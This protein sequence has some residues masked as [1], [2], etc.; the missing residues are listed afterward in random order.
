MIRILLAY[1]QVDLSNCTVVIANAACRDYLQAVKLILADLRCLELD[2]SD[3]MSRAVEDEATEVVIYLLSLPE[4]NP[5]YDNNSALRHSIKNGDATVV[6]A[7]LS[8]PRVERNNLSASFSRA[9]ENGYTEVVR[10]LLAD[11]RFKLPCMTSGME[12]AIERNRVEVVRLI[13]EDGR[14]N[15]KYLSIEQTPKNCSVEMVKLLLSDKR[16][17]PTTEFNGA[18]RN[19]R[20]FK[21]VDVEMLLLQDWR[22]RALD[23]KRQGVQQLA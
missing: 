10:L 4:V 20:K 5:T 7:L 19:A 12:K 1:P 15:T 21:R 6:A 14:Y 23:V 9:L 11:S 18:L 2:L 3:M 13:I 17:D 22:V 16:I 8:D